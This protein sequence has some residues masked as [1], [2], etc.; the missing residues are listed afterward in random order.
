M[1]NIGITGGIG[2][3]KSTVCKIFELYGI[4][5]YYADPRAKRLMTGDKALKSKIKDLLGKEAYYRNGRLNRS[6]VANKIFNDKDLLRQLN[7]LVH[8][9][10]GED[11]NKWSLTAKS[12]FVLK[13]AALLIDNGSYKKLDGLILVV[14]DTDVRISRVMARDNASRKEVQQ[15]INHQRNQE[16][17]KQYADYIIDNSGSKSLILQVDKIYHQIIKKHS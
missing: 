16:D 6:Y 8:P 13:E 10:V 11:F 17:N 9:A 7:G 4:E 1:I 2:S 3:G 5:V 15:R 12:P 14:A